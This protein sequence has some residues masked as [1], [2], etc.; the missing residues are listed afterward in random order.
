MK[1]SC[2]Q[3][4]LSRGLQIVS[5][6]V[7]TR[8]T[9][10]VLNNILIKTEKGRLKLSA[11]D[12]E[13][14]I[15]TWIG[16]KVDADGAVTCPAR[17]ISEFT[18]TNTDKTINLELKDA[19]LHLA[20][21]H[22][23]A[24]IKGIEASEFPLIPEVKGNASIQ[25][26]ATDLKDAISKTVFAC[27]LDETRPVLA[28]V[29]MIVDSGKIKLVATDSYRLAEKTI[30]TLSKDA[31][32]ASYIIPARTM[33]EIGRLIDEPLE[34]VDI[35][36]GENQIQF[37]LGPTEV[38]SRLIEGSFPDYEQIIPTSIK[39][40]IELNTTEFTNAIKMASFFARESAN[41]IKIVMKKPKTIQVLAVSP[42]IGDNT[43]DISAQINGDDLE[44]A[45]NSKFLLDALQV[46]GTEKVDLEMA[47][48]LSPGIIRPSKDKNYLYIIMPLRT[49][50]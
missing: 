25:L 7:G 38:V 18:S 12:L 29:Y 10:P 22:F 50:E 31:L 2:T 5:H 23:K 33:A 3:E 14:G 13:I 26:G 41:N 20:S 28:G 40:R 11:T 44:I 1:V 6:M 48:Q 30:S 8:T 9:L 46:L 45:F 16:A 39:T 34:K 32:K 42:Q 37:Q 24:N 21:E 19:T 36:V 4:N 49:E 15:S 35:K 17:L 47:G 27:A 43:S